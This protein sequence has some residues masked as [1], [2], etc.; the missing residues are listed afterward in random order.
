MSLVQKLLKYVLSVVG[1]ES[2]R[3]KNHKN[4]KMKTIIEIALSQY[5]VREIAGKTH[6]AVILAYFKEIGHKWVKTDETAWCS[7]FANWCAMKA[8]LKR[9]RKLNARSWL[10]VGNEVK[11]PTIGDIVIFWRDKPTS[12]KGHVGIYIGN[13][14]DKIFVLGGNQNNCVCI[15]SYPV[16]RLLAYRSI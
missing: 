9:S 14:K 7:A 11:I 1:K 16:K 4:N 2:N 10:K 6:N 13:T 12:W 5:G 8:C 3:N 15:K